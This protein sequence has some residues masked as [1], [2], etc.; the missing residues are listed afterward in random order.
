MIKKGNLDALYRKLDFGNVGIV[1]IFFAVQIYFADRAIY[2]KTISFIPFEK[3]GIGAVEIL[4]V[5]AM[6]GTGH[7]FYA[8]QGAKLD[9]VGSGDFTFKGNRAFGGYIPDLVFDFLPDG[10]GR[11][12]SG[13][14][15]PLEMNY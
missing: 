3:R 7:H 8:G 9:A 4:V 15:V 2:A 13:K 1:I 12:S 14:P 6:H 10:Y 11:V 5:A